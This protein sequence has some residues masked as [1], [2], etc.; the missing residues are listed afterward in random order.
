MF[1]TANVATWSQLDPDAI[2]AG[3]IAH[4]FRPGQCRCPDQR[5]F[6][7]WAIHHPPGRRRRCADHD[8][9]GG[10]AGR[11]WLVFSRGLRDDNRDGDKLS[12][13]Q[14]AV[15]SDMAL[16]KSGIKRLSSPRR[17]PTPSAARGRTIT[18]SN[19]PASH[20]HRIRPHRVNLPRSG[21]RSPPSG[22]QYRVDQIQ[23]APLRPAEADRRRCQQHRPRRQWYAGSR[24]RLGWTEVNIV[25]TDL[26]GAEATA[27]GIADNR[28][29]E[30]AEWDAITLAK[31]L[32]EPD[33]GDVGFS[34]SEL[35][36]ITGDCDNSQGEAKMSINLRWPANLKSQ[37]SAPM[38][39]N[40]EP[41]TT[42]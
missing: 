35:A 25:R 24:P 15:Y 7:R 10:G 12:A 6:P 41:F 34:E 29:G 8:L 37:S 16:Y 36:E 2:D 19:N 38:R 4:R 13:R 5:L 18:R 39:S 28:T 27:Y 11:R 30:L 26:K 17:W 23:P 14:L 33:I 22:P 1:G 42:N 3:R 31:L 40:K 32:A 20:E 21:Q 9:L